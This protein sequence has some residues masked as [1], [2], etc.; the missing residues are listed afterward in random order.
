M[1]RTSARV[2]RTLPSG[3]T[4]LRPLCAPT[5][6]LRL[7]RDRCLVRASSSSSTSP[8]SPPP[9]ASTRDPSH[10]FLHYHALPLRGRLALSL[11][12]TPPRAPRTVIGYL[13][14]GAGATLDDFVPE[15][16]FLS[17]LHEAIKDGLAAGAAQ[18]VE[19]EAAT[20][21]SDGYIHITD[22]RAVPPAGRIGETEDLIAS[23]FV[24]DGKLVLDTYEPLPS[25]RTVT[26][27]GV[28]LLPRGLDTHVVGY[29]SKVDATEG[30]EG[31]K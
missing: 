5:A 13:P 17:T 29:L 22:E 21:P 7:A 14:L 11:L 19:F 18:T 12:P 24:Q 26:P 2:T 4:S 27:N 8:P 6:P 30:G 1:L 16:A 9:P 25:Y 28:V 3:A 15:P 10:P 20:R 23:V 31:G